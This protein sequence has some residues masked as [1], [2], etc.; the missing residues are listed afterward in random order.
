MPEVSRA[1]SG[2]ASLGFFRANVSRNVY[3][4]FAVSVMRQSICEIW[5]STGKAT[6]WFSR[7]GLA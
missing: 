5:H 7:S 1:I 6:Q 4:S 3:S 2:L